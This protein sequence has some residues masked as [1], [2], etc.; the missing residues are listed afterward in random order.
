MNKGEATRQ[1]ILE[2]SFKLLNKKGFLVSPVSDIMKV[3]GLKKGGIYNHFESKQD[4]VLQVF[5]YAVGRVG[6]KFNRVIRENDTATGRLLG[7]ISVFKKYFEYPDLAGGC[8]VMNI[9]IE[10]DDADPVLRQRARD[11]MSRWRDMCARIVT[12]GINNGEFRAGVNPD[13]VATLFI[14][15][16]EGAVMLSNL[17]KD[18]VHMRRVV[19]HLENYVE[20]EVK[21]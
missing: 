13:A 20:K 4:L 10:S 16:L 14:A 21:A 9:A 18:T 12:K 5:D 3:T 15:S 1:R 8:P 17:Y 19:E 7:V 11:A 2:K 6:E